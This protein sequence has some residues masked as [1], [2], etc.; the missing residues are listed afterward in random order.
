MGA[1]HRLAA[2]LAESARPLSAFPHGVRPLPDAR[3]RKYNKAKALG[4]LAIKGRTAHALPASELN[5]IDQPTVATMNSDAGASVTSRLAV[6]L[7]F[8]I[9]FAVSTAHAEVVLHPDGWTD[10]DLTCGGGADAACHD[11]ADCSYTTG[12]GIERLLVFTYV[13]EDCNALAPHDPQVS[14]TYGGQAMT[15]AV[16][17]V[18]INGSCFWRSSIFCLKEADIPAG[19][20]DFIVSGQ[21]LW[22]T[23]HASYAL[24]TGVDQTAPILDTEFGDADNTTATVSTQASFTVAPGGMAVASATSSSGN[25]NF[26]DWSGNTPAWTEGVDIDRCSFNSS[27]ANT[28]I[29]YAAG[30]TTDSVSVVVGWAIDY[31]VITAMSLNPVAPHNHWWD[32]DWKNRKKIAFDNS[33]QSE[34]LTD[35]LVLVW[36]DSTNFDYSKTQP[37]GIDIRF[38][39]SDD[40]TVLDYEIEEWN[41]GGTS[42]VWVRVPQVR[43]NSTDDSIF[44]YYS[45]PT[46]GAGA[47]NAPG[48]WIRGYESVYHLHDD[49]ADTSGNHVAATN[50]GSADGNV[51]PLVGDYQTFDPSETDFID[52]NWTS[53]YGASQDFTWSG[54][55]KSRPSGIRADDTILGI[56]D[57]GGGD[58]SELRFAFRETAAGQ[59]NPPDVWQTFAWPDAGGNYSNTNALSLTPDVWY[60][61]VMMRDGATARMFLNGAQIDN[62]PIGTGAITFPGGANNTLLIG[63]QYDTAIGGGAKRNWFLGHI[64]EVRT[65]TTRRFADWI[66]AQYLSVTCAYTS[67]GA[68]QDIIYVR[69]VGDAPNYVVGDVDATQGSKVV[70]GNGTM[71]LMANR[72]RGDHIN[73]NGTD[74]VI[75]SVDTETQ[76]TLTSAFD[77]SS[78]MNLPY[79]I[80]RQFLDLQPWEDCVDNTAVCPVFPVSSNNLV[81][82]ERSEI[83]VAY[84]DP[85]THTALLIDDSI[86]DAFHTIT[87]TVDHA[88]RHYGIE[89]QGAVLD[90]GINVNDGLRI[91]DDFVTVEWL[92]IK[93]GAVGTDGIEV[94][95]IAVSNQIVLRNLVVH[96]VGQHGISGTGVE[97][98]LDAY[99][100]IIYDVV[101]VG[102]RLAPGPPNPGT[103]VR[104]L[105]NTIYSNGGNGMRSLGGGPD[106]PFLVRN[107]I[108]HGNVGVSYLF[109]LPVNA[110]SSNNLASD[111]TATTHSP[112]GG[113][114]DSVCL[115]GAGCVNFVDDASPGLDLHLLPTSFAIGKATDLSGTLFYD[116]DGGARQT[117]WDIGADD[118]DA[119]TAVQ[120][121]SFAAVGGDGEIV[122]RWETGSEIDNLGFDVYRATSRASSPTSG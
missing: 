2:T 112:A 74:Y 98:N 116:I 15:R 28:S 103:S 59:P 39:D 11:P 73:I 115:S 31:E 27:T 23:T 3:P 109:S 101:D 43:G 65:A 70:D 90:N 8:G 102:I 38:V 37:G 16:S 35:F 54:W 96:D 111:G 91:R 77:Q 26:F 17:H 25:P 61:M 68:E 62:Q 64:D 22:S 87:L 40:V 95:N 69:F 81:N 47:P 105:N 5:P 6:A 50:G 118:V 57:R 114:R 48:V 41:P 120:L 107:N 29:A 121:V 85:T 21:D 36:L 75:Q 19:S 44:I 72:G 18:R 99:N 76:L 119:T 42:Y 1:E 84:K 100:N 58:N 106:T 51:I 13:H 4:S 122:L 113:G 49:F 83:G 86:T 92:E 71:W 34:N 104:I 78:A 9:A 24:Y 60:Y 93:N 7:I 53:N 66:A 79:T 56:E 82:D 80:A 12:T 94:R 20:N 55:I 110:A 45:N 63:A 30:N 14:V 88:N 67:V 108:S 33:G 117:P 46:V 97:L 32:T 52:L 10:P 89:G